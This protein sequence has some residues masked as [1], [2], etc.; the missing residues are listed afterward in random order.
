MVGHK[1]ANGGAQRRRTQQSRMQLH[2]EKL[3]SIQVVVLANA[4]RSDEQEQ[5]SLAT[6]GTCEEL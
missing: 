4:D 3:P 1:E 2:D 5:C 6:M